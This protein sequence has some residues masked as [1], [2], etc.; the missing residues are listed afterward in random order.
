MLYT[1]CLLAQRMYEC[2]DGGLP[3]VGV[4]VGVELGDGA[5][6]EGGEE[7]GVYMNV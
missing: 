5:T 2:G 6:E 1:T 4:D 7:L 3:F